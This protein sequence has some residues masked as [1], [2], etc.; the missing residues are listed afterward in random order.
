MAYFPLSLILGRVAL[1]K[2][3]GLAI[4][5]VLL[6]SLFSVSENVYGFDCIKAIK[7]ILNAGANAERLYQ[8]VLIQEGIDLSNAPSR[9]VFESALGKEF[10]DGEQVLQ[11][12]TPLLSHPGNIAGRIFP[13]LG[14]LSTIPKG[15]KPS[16][17]KVFPVFSFLL[18]ESEV[19]VYGNIAESSH[20]F[21]KE[22][23]GE[24]FYQYFVY[25]LDIDL[26]KR[27]L[28]NAEYSVHWATATSS[29]RTILIQDPL[30]KD[31]QMYKL[32]MHHRSGALFGVVGKLNGTPRLRKIPPISDAIARM[33]IE[34][35]D[36][37]PSGKKWEVMDESI[38]M[39]PNEGQL[40]GVIF[41]NTDNV[42]SKDQM[43]LTLY[44]LFSRK[45]N[46]KRWI[47]EMFENSA[48]TK[49]SEFVFKEIIKPVL[50]FY[51]MLAFR[52]GLIPQ[53]H[54]QNLVLVLNKQT[55]QLEKVLYRDIEGMH[56]DHVT[57]VHINGQNPLI[58]DDFATSTRYFNYDQSP[59]KQVEGYFVKFRREAIIWAFR[60][61]IPVSLGSV[62]KDMD[63]YMMKLF[64]EAFPGQQLDRLNLFGDRFV[65]MF[66]RSTTA[67]ERQIY[68]QVARENDSRSY[69][70]GMR[71]AM[72]DDDFFTNQDQFGN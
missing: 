39:I 47:Q 7:R 48:Y 68:E 40:G 16:E 72:S 70:A 5:L 50:E 12:T 15:L 59:S 69:R 22:I 23:N 67:Q 29:G 65:E 32:S 3:F 8:Q 51:T 57:R 27:R 24:K 63:R 44:S 42:W 13:N 1:E 4:H 31:I 56:V 38:S 66:D 17:G 20:R 26:A 45:P 28:P 52:N 6:F 35:G 10:L 41:R 34:S 11:Q 37:L 9:T 14:L 60:S 19:E 21:V 36:T 49:K 53:F 64:E 54:Q 2:R 33:K 25:P 61:Y 43:G 71:K 58:V 18:K 30:T 55:K 62:L 46:G